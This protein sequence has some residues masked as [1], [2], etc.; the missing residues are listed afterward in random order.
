MKL[1]FIKLFPGSCLC[2]KARN[3]NEDKG[4]ERDV[5]SGLKRKTLVFSLSLAAS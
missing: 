3:I 5:L 1:N 2:K 4:F